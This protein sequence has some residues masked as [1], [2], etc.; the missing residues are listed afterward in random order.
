MNEPITISMTYFS[1]NQ[2]PRMSAK[3]VVG[4]YPDEKEKLLQLAKQDRRTLSDYVRGILLDKLEASN[5]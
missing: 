4:V 2:G 3:C 5:V 1:Q